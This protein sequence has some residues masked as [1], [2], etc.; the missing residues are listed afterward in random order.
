[1]D[2]V[3]E[4]FLRK[5]RFYVR[6]NKENGKQNTIP[7]ANYIWL[8]Y[9]PAFKAIPV[10]YVIHHLDHDQVND[11]PSNL[12]LMQKYHHAAYHWKHK[13]IVPEILFDKEYSNEYFPTRKPTVQ[14]HGK[15]FYVQFMQKNED[16]KSEIKKIYKSHG[17]NFRSREDAEKFANDLWEKSLNFRVQSIEEK[18]Y[19]SR[20][21]TPVQ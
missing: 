8:K 16:G 7:R 19:D 10:G 9:N 20:G 14:P 15:C 5:D 3:N 21:T 2:K 12:V 13:I 1:M 11:D 4:I 17:E 6:F 18:R